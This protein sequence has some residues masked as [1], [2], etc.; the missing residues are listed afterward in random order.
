M[1]HGAH[2]DAHHPR[3]KAAGSTPAVAAQMTPMRIAGQWL[4]AEVGQTEPD[5][6]VEDHGQREL[7]SDAC[8]CGKPSDC[9]HK[10]PELDE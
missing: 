8:W 10:H 3:W 2:Q 5:Q 9:G 7:F 4:F 6:V 1:L